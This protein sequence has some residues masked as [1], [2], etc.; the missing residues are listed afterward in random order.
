M[1]RVTLIQ[2]TAEDLEEF[3]IKVIERYRK[4]VEGDQEL[5]IEQAAARRRVSTRT[6]RNWIK[7]E[8]NRLKAQAINGRSYAI[9][10][11]DLD[12]YKPR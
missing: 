7:N 5:S 12:N 4:E 10:L 9:K 3:G 6:I 8:D 1:N 11:R 2:L